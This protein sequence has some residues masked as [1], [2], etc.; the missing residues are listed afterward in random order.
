MDLEVVKS[1][2]ASVQT[3]QPPVGVWDNS[4]LI[5]DTF[6]GSTVIGVLQ[7]IPHLVLRE[8]HIYLCKDPLDLVVE[9]EIKGCARAPSYSELGGR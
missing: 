6:K 5:A 1:P 4:K 9:V 7:D 3:L 8:Q 2:Q